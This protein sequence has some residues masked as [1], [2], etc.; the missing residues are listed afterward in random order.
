[1]YV[2]KYCMVILAMLGKSISIF[3]LKF[4]FLFGTNEWGSNCVF[5]KEKA[6]VFHIFDSHIPHF[7]FCIK[8]IYSY[9]DADFR[10]YQKISKSLIS[11]TSS[12]SDWNALFNC[13][14]MYLVFNFSIRSFRVSADNQINSSNNTYVWVSCDWSLKGDVQIK[15]SIII[16]ILIL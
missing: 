11:Y 2:C 16:C 12:Q 3:F 6:K 1:M 13:L 7:R 4:R 15:S 14:T 10:Y 8:Y 5:G 9:A